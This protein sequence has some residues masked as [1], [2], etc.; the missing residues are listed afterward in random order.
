MS[1]PPSNDWRAQGNDPHRRPTQSDY[2]Q[3]VRGRGFT[4][5]YQ[6]PSQPPLPPKGLR[7]RVKQYRDLRRQARA[8]SMSWWMVKAVQGVIT[9]CFPFAI[10]IVLVVVYT[11]GGGSVWLSMAGMGMVLGGLAII[12]WYAAAPV[13]CKWIVTVPENRYWV[14]EDGNG[15]TAEYLPPGRLIV[16]FRMNSRVH[17]YVDFHTII[18]REMYEDVLRGS[19]RKVD[20][21]VNVVLA[22]NPAEADPRLYA[23]LRTLARREQFEDLVANT[24]RD[25]VSRYFTRLSPEFWYSALQDQKILEEQITDQLVGLESM[26]LLLASSQPV[27]VFVHG[28]TLSSAAAMPGTSL[29]ESDWTRRADVALSQ[30]RISRDDHQPRSDPLPDQSFDQQPTMR[31]GQTFRSRDSDAGSG[32]SEGDRQPPEPLS[33]DLGVTMPH[34]GTPAFIPGSFEGETDIATL[35]QHAKT[36]DQPKDERR[37][38][39]TDASERDQKQDMGETLPRTTRPDFWIRR[40]K[41][42]D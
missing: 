20:L 32:H 23:R 9:G 2:E 6:A 41:D 13:T 33:D 16:P 8:S 31:H 24:I 17:D 14:V 1:V 18:V 12:G 19:G 27:T 40:R 21:E 34:G 37:A 25:S 42:Q 35:L 22:F 39:R 36:G 5:P 10:G 29:D 4:V 3:V 30:G 28:I 26:G 15:H 11:L 7:R 38:R